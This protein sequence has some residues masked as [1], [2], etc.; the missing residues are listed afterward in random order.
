MSDQFVQVNGMSKMARCAPVGYF[1]RPSG[2]WEWSGHKTDEGYGKVFG[3]DLCGA[4][5]KIAHRWM[6]ECLVGPI[7]D[8]LEIDH[9]CRNRGCVNPSHLE[10]V[11][12]R[13]NVLRGDGPPA[14]N[15]RKTHCRNGHPLTG[16]NVAH[17]GGNLN[18]R[19]CRMCYRAKNKRYELSLSRG[20][21]ETLP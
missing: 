5:T 14:R 15:A 12:T 21:N 2:C 13:E 4:T 20:K 6:Y 16:D 17:P 8:G 1:V 3:K 9:L 11:T 18:K 19:R 10:P 7:P